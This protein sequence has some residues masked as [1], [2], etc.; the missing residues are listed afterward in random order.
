M[1]KW[2]DYI[3]VWC[4]AVILNENNQVLLMKRNQN[5]RNKSWWWTIPWWWVEF[6]ET[7]ETAIIRE[8]KEEI[9]LDIEVVKLLALSDDIMPEENQH[10]ITP[11]YLCKVIWWK[12]ENCEENK[13]I[14]WNGFL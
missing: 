11:Q 5:C 4:W 7:F 13:V 2:I 1:K 12:L 6:W 3:W 14:L 10:W 9:W 8:I